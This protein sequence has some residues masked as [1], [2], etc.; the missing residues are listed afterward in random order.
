[1]NLRIARRI[2]IIAIIVSLSLTALIGIFT[3]LSGDFGE[4]QGK[5]LLSTLLLGGFSITVLCH[6]AV[7]GRALQLVGF[8]GVA[9]SAVALIAGLF[10]IWNNWG[11]YGDV[12]PALRTFGVFGVLAV[13]IAHANLL[14]LLGQR[15][16]T[17]VRALLYLTVAFVGLVAV[18]LCLPI[19][20]AGDIPGD[21]GDAYWRLFGVVGILDVLGSIVLPVTGRFLRDER[22]IRLELELSEE[23]NAKLTAAA[24]GTTR[25]AVAIAAL[26]QQL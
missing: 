5:V 17:V 16:N 13:S 12:D 14:L 19:A 3:L 7:V 11:I 20:T 2:A 10:L 9:V 4:T 26:E 21:N 24:V 1:M 15:R 18:L 25:E 6:L 23:L 8:A 22:R